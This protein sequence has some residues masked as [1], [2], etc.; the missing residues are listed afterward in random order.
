MNAILTKEEWETMPVGLFDQVEDKFLKYFQY[1]VQVFML[2]LL[3]LAPF[4]FVVVNDSSY[5]VAAVVLLLDRSQ[6]LF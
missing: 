1:W 3:C 4:S 5:L 2:L 6:S